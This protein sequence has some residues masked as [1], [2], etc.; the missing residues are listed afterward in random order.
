MRSKSPPIEIGRDG[1]KAPG[2]LRFSGLAAALTAAGFFSIGQVGATIIHDYNGNEPTNDDPSGATAGNVGDEFEGCVGAGCLDAVTPQPTFRNDPA[3][4]VVYPGLNAA[5]TYTLTIQEIAEVFDS[6]NSL[7]FS[8]F[9]NGS[10][11]A[12][13]VQT[14]GPAVALFTYTFPDF[15]LL[16]SLMVGVTFGSNNPGGCC[17]GYSVVLTQAGGGGTAPEPATV[18]LLAAGILGALAARRRKRS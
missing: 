2:R 11:S 9:L 3:D 6:P 18:A 14:L 16:S 5:F 10:A 17:E 8:V 15:S 1:S 4:Y 7:D 13:Y 12:S